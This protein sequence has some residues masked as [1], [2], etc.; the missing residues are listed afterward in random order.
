MLK[1]EK[2][3]KDYVTPSMTINALKEVSITFR[4]SELV[5]ILGPSGCGKT[6]LL[7]IIGGLDQYTSGD[8]IIDNISTKKFKDNDWDTYRN[9]RIGFVFQSYNLISHQTILENVELALTISGIGKEERISRAKKVLDDVGLKDLYHKKPNQL[10]G[11]QCQRVAIARALVNEPEILLAD[12]P[13]GALDTKTS[14]QIMNLLKTIAQDRLVIMVTHNPE[15]AEQYSTR[16]IRLLDGEVQSDSNPYHIGEIKKTSYKEK[17]R[18]SRL[19]FFQAIRLSARNL[20]SKFKRTLL[21]CIAGSIGIIGVATVLAVSSGVTGYINN[22]Q[23]D[24]LS[25]NP[26][27]IAEESINYQALLS[28]INPESSNDILIGAYE[29]GHISVQYILDY[30]IKMSQDLSNSQIQNDITEEY[31]KFLRQ[32]HNELYSAIRFKY[33][34]DL[35]YNI[36]TDM[37]FEQLGTRKISISALKNVFISMLKTNDEFKD[38]STIISQLSAPMSQSFDN[39]EY[40]LSQYDIVSDRN[41]SKIATEK[42]EIMIVLNDDDTLTDLLLA[43]LGYYTQEEFFNI[44][45]KSVGSSL[46]NPAL[47]IENFSYDAL[48]GKEFILYNNDDV[49]EANLINKINPFNYNMNINDA[50]KGT[51]LK[52]TAILSPKENVSYGSL[53]SGFYYS[54]SL[55]E[56]FIQENLD[57]EIVSYINNTESKEISSGVMGQMSYGIKYDYNFFINGIEYQD[58]GFVGTM[59]MYP[60]NEMTVSYYTLKLRNVGG[61]NIPSSI[62]I[63]PTDFATKDKVV[64]YL[65]LWNSDQDIIIDGKIITKEMRNDIQYTDNLELIIAMVNN[66]IQIVTSALVAFTSLSLVVSTVMISII[67]YVSVIERV[68]EIGIIRSLGGRKKDVSRLF[69]AETLII[70]L[71]AGFIG[72]LITYGLTVIINLVVG[73]FTGIYSIAVLK[74]S[75]AFIMITVSII[76]TVI[77]GLIPASLAAKKDP[78]VA[79]R[80]E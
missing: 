76:L 31:I 13:T 26:I 8:L 55:V 28:M 42:D 12:E 19:S 17:T 54:Q 27:N 67:T 24:L 9:H 38:F 32:M 4:D 48:L 63:Y 75:V 36:Y 14:I 68:K 80:S 52:I 5:S 50:S 35:D 51:K 3:S 39:E 41:T 69:N 20:H 10:S 79:L 46:Y 43:Q 59:A 64:E 23:E 6:T 53:Q 11:G 33:G 29:D 60:S 61:S 49:Y 16:I 74:P 44:L 21:V 78:V 15:L 7:N 71:T 77:S 72:I 40:I 37:Q 2:I 30:L 47:D 57:S 34:V 62:D 18:K 22:M 25:G 73:S 58:T 70:G 45:Y 56:N 65:D 1:L 66:M